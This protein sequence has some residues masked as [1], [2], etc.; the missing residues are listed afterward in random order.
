MALFDVFP[1]SDPNS[2]FPSPAAMDR[3]RPDAKKRRTAHLHSVKCGVLLVLRRPVVV[4]PLLLVG[5]YC[6]PAGLLLVF[7]V[8]TLVAV[9]RC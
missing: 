1:L 3:A 9:D 5:W 6:L 7:L 8:E 4:V 2:R